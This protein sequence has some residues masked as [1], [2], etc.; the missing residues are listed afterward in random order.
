ME[1]YLFGPA[2]N[3]FG[4]PNDLSH[5]EGETVAAQI[6]HRLVEEDQLAV[7]D[8]VAHRHEDNVV[9]QGGVLRQERDGVVQV[10]GGQNQRTLARSFGPV[11]DARNEQGSALGVRRPLAEFVQENE[12]RTVGASQ[13]RR[14]QGQ[15]HAELREGRHCRLGNVVQREHVR[16]RRQFQTF[17]RHEAADLSHVTDQRRL[18]PFQTTKMVTRQFGGAMERENLKK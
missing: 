16:Q 13:C 5:A 3:V 14:Q 2:D 18:L 1:T 17:G 9:V 10:S 8:Q 6:G 7:F 4:N 15:L 11:F 12:R